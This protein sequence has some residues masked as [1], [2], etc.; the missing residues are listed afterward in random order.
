MATSNTVAL[1]G[2]IYDLVSGK[3]LGPSLAHK[4]LKAAPG[5][6]AHAVHRKTQHAKTLM[7]SA[8]KPPKPR[9]PHSVIA[10]AKKAA[11]LSIN[12]I[13]PTHLAQERFD[14]SKAIAKSKLIS[15]FNDIAD[16]SRLV[17]KTAVIPVKAEPDHIITRH[18]TPIIDAL[19]VPISP[20]DIFAEAVDKA[21]SH[22]EKTKRRGRIHKAAGKIG[23]SSKVLAVSSAALSVALLV[24][25]FIYQNAPNAAFRV[26]AAQ[27]GVRA[28]LPGYKP[29]GFALYG[30]VQSAPGEVTVRYQ[31]NTDARAYT[32][33][34]K[35]SSWNSTALLDNYVATNN[36]SGYQAMQSKGRTVYIYD[37]TSATW[38]DGGVWYQIE[39]DSNLSSDQLLQ[40]AASM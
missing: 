34:Q 16:R 2:K 15:R 27:A 32:L 8:V 6:A 29:S 1:N 36:H 11:A 19:A 14:R 5:T 24:G 20:I 13:L 39:G 4:K 28:V 30:P 35:A 40:I 23:V 37:D 31:S 18:H 38:V 22:T 10:P 9:Q 26:A 7:R 12:P 33:K 21:T 3:P 17:K 25:F